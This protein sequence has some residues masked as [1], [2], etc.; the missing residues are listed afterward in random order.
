MANIVY[1]FLACPAN[2]H[3]TATGGATMS[4]ELNYVGIAKNNATSLNATLTSMYQGTSLEGLVSGVGAWSWQKFVCPKRGKMTATV[5]GGAGGVSSATAISINAVTGAASDGKSKPGRG[6]KLVGTFGVN[7]GDI[8]YISVGFR[9]F[10]HNAGGSWAAGGGGASTILRVNPNGKYTFALTNEKVDVLFVAG[11]GGGVATPNFNGNSDWM[12]EDASPNNGTSTNGGIVVGT[13]TNNNYAAGGSGLTGRGVGNG[14]NA[15][16]A[17]AA[18]LEGI[19]IAGSNSSKHCWGGGGAGQVAGGGGGG[20]SGGNSRSHAGGYGG[21]S[22]MNPNYITPVSRGFATVTEDKNRDLINPWT[23]YGNIELEFQANSNFLLA[24]DDDGIKYFNGTIDAEN[25]ANPTGTDTWELLPTGTILSENTYRLYGKYSPTNKIGLKEDKKVK[26]LCMSE[27]Q[28]TSITIDGKINKSTVKQNQD[29][30]VSDIAL[31]TDIAATA[32][33][34]IADIK[35]AISKNSG[36]TWQAYNGVDFVDI[37]I[38]D[39]DNFATNGYDLSLIKSIPL[40]AWNNYKAKTLRFAF[41]VTQKTN[42][43]A[44]VL[45]KIVFTGNLIGSWRKAKE[46]EVSYEYT[47]I[48]NLRVTF[49]ESGNYKVNYLDSITS[50]SSGSGS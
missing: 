6:A 46:S 27:E 16:Q 31:I 47:A 15:A 43:T 19:Y 30:I 40:E 8:L 33:T 1:K 45:N 21:T 20:Y 34:S 44:T 13:I 25:N 22:Y 17:P 32:N 9:G 24:Q 35:F 28:E 42:S 29:T 37:D 4:D 14:G 50:G 12:G 36:K 23:A 10:C 7:T 41:C 48:D 2:K 11:G 26:F 18:I 38:S 3:F 49:A 5:R 39:R